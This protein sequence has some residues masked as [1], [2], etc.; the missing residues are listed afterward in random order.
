MYTY[1]L[2]DV[3]NIKKQGF[4]YT[5]SEHTSS[6][7]IELSKLVGATDYIKTPIF[8]NKNF[9][10]SGPDWDKIK[11][12]KP[13]AKIDRSVNDN[14]IQSIKG[15]LHKM[16][17]KNYDKM[18][19]DIFTNLKLLESSP[20]YSTINDIIYNIASSNR[21][22]SSI[23]ARLYKELIEQSDDDI[24]NNRLRD[25]LSNYFERF[26]TIQ[27]VNPN[28]DYDLFCNVNKENEQR[29]A[30]TEFFMNLLL[31]KVI[32]S[33][34]IINIFN[35]LYDLVIDISIK[36]DKRH[37]MIELSENIFIIMESCIRHFTKEG[38]YK[39]MLDKIQV[40]T[41]NMNLKSNPGLT[42]K[43]LFKFMDIMDIKI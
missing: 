28:E 31:I 33:T 9:D 7:I 39:I 30:L 40:I 1:S 16:T 27:I 26:S 21:F 18:R 20:E 5:L 37:I 17:H 23:Y 4:V 25:E 34:D 3:I 35:K 19:D 2:D 8:L 38:E 11:Q 13:T 6:M 15:S 14:I 32:P 29:K 22:Y 36:K 43:A 42:N 12:F 41:D 24:F 10:T